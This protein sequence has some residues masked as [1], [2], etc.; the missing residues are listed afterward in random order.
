ME[1]GKS[2]VQDSLV[3]AGQVYIY[4]LFNN[5]KNKSITVKD[6]K[7]NV[8]L[9]GLKYF[10]QING[11]FQALNKNTEIIY[12]NYNLKKL[13]SPPEPEIYGYCGNVSQY[14]LKIEKQKNNYLI[15]K[16][17]A[18]GKEL[19]E[20]DLKTIGSI[21][22]KDVNDI[23]FLNGG[24]TLY[25]DDN[26]RIPELIIIQ[27]EDY[28]G[29]Y[30]NQKIT[31]YDYVIDTNLPLKVMRNNHYGYYDITNGTPYKELGKYENNL[32]PIKTDANISGFIDII[33][34]EY[35]NNE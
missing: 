29:I 33:G 12:Y 31:R 9:E 25:Y 34:N 18:F 17:E 3:F 32:A 1:S 19:S 30:D 21:S 35:L 2:V 27:F 14:M 10:G 16:A 4:T 6:K 23:C 5:P 8:K 24:R 20:S 7:G 13:N 22:T 15:K 26:F 11:G 28:F